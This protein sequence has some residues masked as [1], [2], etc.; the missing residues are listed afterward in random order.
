MKKLVYSPAALASLQD[1]LEWTIERFGDVQAQKY[2]NQLIDRLEL[3]ASGMPP[4]PRSCT[5]LLSRKHKKTDLSFYREGQHYLILRESAETLELV[6]IFHGRF[7]I[8]A[9]LGDLNH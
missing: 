4:H 8:E 9:R 7:D 1:I 6:E 3:L 2:T 5:L